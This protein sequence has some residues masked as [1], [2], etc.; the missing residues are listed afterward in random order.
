[1][2]RLVSALLVLLLLLPGPM[3]HVARAADPSAED[4]ARAAELKRRGDTAID[5]MRYGEAVDAYT[6]AYA[7]TQDP[8]LLYNRARALQALG[9][10]PGALEGLEGFA[11]AASPELKAR[12][13]K[14]TDLLAEVRAHV[15]SLVLTCNVAGA[16]VLLRNQVVGTTPLQGPLRTTAGAASLE[17][18]AEGYLPYAKSL[19]LPP[20]GELDLEVSL[21]S[22]ATASILV[23]RAPVA[24]TTAI[25]DGKVAGNPPVEVVVQPGAHRIVARAEGYADSETSAV[26]SPGEHKQMDLMLK[27]KPGLT[28]QWWFWAG[29]GVVALGGAAVTAALLIERKPSP[30]DLAPGTIGAP[31]RF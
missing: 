28:S 20:G 25:V 10:F 16:R 22:K 29:V 24:G 12:V 19:D 18:T 11:N 26:V 15:A 31:I 14:L 21:L 2:K 6:Q 9:D 3:V 8:A 4:R 30:G 13:P 5:S 7:I 27:Q 17:V 23:L 1:M